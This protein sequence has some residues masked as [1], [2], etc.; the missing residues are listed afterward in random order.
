MRILIAEDD[1]ISLKL[2]QK[3]LEPYGVCDLAG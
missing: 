2:M 3:F 1:F